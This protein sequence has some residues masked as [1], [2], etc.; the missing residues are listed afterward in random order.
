M[1]QVVGGA[2]SGLY[3]ESLEDEI[4]DVLLEESRR[5]FQKKKNIF[6]QEEVPLLSASR[7]EAGAAL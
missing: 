3:K 5:D 2:F 7:S 6:A 4:I 1:K